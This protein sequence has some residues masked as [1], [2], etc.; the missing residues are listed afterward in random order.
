[1]GRIPDDITRIEGCDCGSQ[2]GRWHRAK[3]PG[4]EPCSLWSL[5]P[6][7]AEANIEDQEQRVRTYF[8][9]KNQ[10][11]RDTGNDYFFVRRDENGQ[12]IE[13]VELTEKE[14]PPAPPLRD[15]PSL[16]DWY[17]GDWQQEMVP[18]SS[19]GQPLP[20][21]IWHLGGVD[22][23]D[24]KPHRRWRRHQPQSRGYIDGK[25]T[26]RCSCGAMRFG[27]HGPWVR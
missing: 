27:G 12:P 2:S 19:G 7:Q 6:E 24:A 17:D 25:L 18:S 10:R 5:P 22:W 9:E 15:N 3:G 23:Y 26:E 11:V 8:D 14:P 4:Q 20:T 21:G 1:M 16:I 13:L